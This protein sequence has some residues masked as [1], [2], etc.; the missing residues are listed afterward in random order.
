MSD[1]HLINTIRLLERTCK[2]R[3]DNELAAAYSV[4]SSLQGEMASYYADQD[5]AAMEEDVDGYDFM[6]EIYTNLLLEAEHRKLET[7]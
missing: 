4:A 3:H 2:T 5:I 1:S 6:P 7:N